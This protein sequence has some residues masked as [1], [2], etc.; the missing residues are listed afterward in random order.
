MGIHTHTMTYIYT[1]TYGIDTIKLWSLNVWLT[2]A[3]H[4]FHI[5]PLR[6][7]IARLSANCLAGFQSLH[8]PLVD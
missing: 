8:N 3:G 6:S 5:L 4:C 7:F 1:M 2:N